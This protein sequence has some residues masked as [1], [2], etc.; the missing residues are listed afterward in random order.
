MPKGTR[1]VL[2]S[3]LGTSIRRIWSASDSAAKRLIAWM[4]FL[5]LGS[6]IVAAFLPVILKLMVDSFEPAGYSATRFPPVFLVFAYAMALLLSRAFGEFQVAF[7][8]RTSQRISRRLS[9]EFFGHILALPLCVHLNQKTGAINKA[10]EDG[11]LG[12]RIILGHLANSLLPMVTQLLTAAIVLGM[13]G[14]FP[15]LLT[16]AV[17]VL[18]YA[19]AFRRGARL[20]ASPARDVSVAHQNAS[21]IF[22]DAVLNVETVKCFGGESDLRERFAFALKNVERRWASLFQRNLKTGLTIASIFALALG[23]SIYIAQSAVLGGAMSTGE[24]VLVNAYILQLTRP[25]E[26]AGFALRDVV[27]SASFIE[28]MME[29]MRL[30][31]ESSQ[32]Q[33][34]KPAAI[35]HSGLVF[36]DVSFYLEYGQPLLRNIRFTIAPGNTLGI[37]GAS[38]SGKST[39]VRLLLRMFDPHEGHIC[40]GGIPLPRLPLSDLRR[41]I[42]VVPQ[43]V[44]LFND[45][46]E[47]NLTFGSSSS[48]LEQVIAAA[49]I[50]QLH[51]FIQGLP[52]GYDTIIGERGT[53]LSG[54]E[55]QRLA[56]ARA[57]FRNSEI[58]VFD[59]A[60]S[61]LDSRTELE[62]LDCLE[63]LSTNKISIVITHRLSAVVRASEIVVMDKGR[64]VERGTHQGLIRFHGLYERLWSVQATD[65]KHDEHLRHGRSLA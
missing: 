42:T 35:S 6:S 58:F 65:G 11:I 57:V 64:I 8:N 18:F 51:D 16:M 21:A 15:I 10:L 54:G 5:S 55:R 2:F 12:H 33:D 63:K 40:I 62:I 32:V 23:F 30:K 24:F 47:R 25:L 41:L 44:A 19:M 36:D 45:T 17:T 38:G 34:V 53:K 22:T 39:L 20:V 52:D 59:E 50:A 29:L 49:K 1:V 56:I 27:Q 60:T 43:D 4:L 7:L 31:Q 14:H 9:D 28:R 13:F 61:S 46:I 48:T 3:I 37:V 26:M